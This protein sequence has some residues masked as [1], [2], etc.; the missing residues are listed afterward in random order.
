MDVFLLLDLKSTHPSWQIRV[1]TLRE[2]VFYGAPGVP[3]L[4][5]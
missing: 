4:Q 3:R 5:G 1:M 2:V